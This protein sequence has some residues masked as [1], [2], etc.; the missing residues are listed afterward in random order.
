[1][2]E[3]E[4][5]RVVVTEGR[6]GGG[7]TAIVAL[8]IIAILVVLFLLFGRDMLSGGGAPEKIDVDI[9]TPATGNGS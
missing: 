1:M 9:S 6:S 4:T 7:S 5:E 8:A 3:R 2:A